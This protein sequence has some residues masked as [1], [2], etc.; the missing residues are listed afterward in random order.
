MVRRV[1]PGRHGVF[2]GSSRQ[3]L[4]ALHDVVS[5]CRT[6]RDAY[7]SV[8]RAIDSPPI[9]FLLTTCLYPRPPPVRLL[10]LSVIST[11]TCGWYEAR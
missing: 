7:R 2:R 10:F 5:R 1:I 6:E 3:V 9:V 8:A 4:E 11:F